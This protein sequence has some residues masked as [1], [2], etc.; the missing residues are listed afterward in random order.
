MPGFAVHHYLWA[1]EPPP[2]GGAVQLVARGLDPN[3]LDDFSASLLPIAPPSA[4]RDAIAAADA[5]AYPDPAC[6]ALRALLAAHHDLPPDQILCANGSVALIQAVARACLSPGDCALVVGPTFSE[7]AAAIQAV[8]GRVVEVQ[9]AA[10]GAVLDAIRTQ[11][12]A[13]VFLCNPNNPTGH[14]WT[15]EA[16]DRIAAAAPL[17]LDEAYAGFLRPSPPAATGPGRLV[18]RSLTKDHALAG[19]RIGYALGEPRLL[20]A[21]ERVLAPW[22]VSAIAQAAAAAALQDPAPYRAAIDALWDERQRLTAGIAALGLTVEPGQAPFFLVRVED[23]AWT[24]A[25]LLDAGIVVRDCSSFGLP[26]HIRISPQRP[27][28]GD[29]LLA[30][31]ADVVGASAGS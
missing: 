25:R 26:C 6:T 30:A 13:L 28:A 5:R 8:G 27:E 31:L 11:A 14:R 1:Y 3:A 23:A 10:V 22:G 29:R 4:V 2:H 7:Y 18:I 16:V 15:T 12:P 24:A 17:V 19:V 9:T 20:S 21:L